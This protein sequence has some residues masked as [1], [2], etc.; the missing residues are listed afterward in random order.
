M[1]MFAKGQ[2][3]VI[4]MHKTG[5]VIFGDE[6]LYVIMEGLIREIGLKHKLSIIAC[7]TQRT[8][9]LFV[10]NVEC[11][12][13]LNCFLE[14]SLPLGISLTL[15]ELDSYF[16]TKIIRKQTDFVKISQKFPLLIDRNRKKNVDIYA[17]EFHFVH[18]KKTFY[19]IEV[20]LEPSAV[21]L[22]KLSRVI[23]KPTFC[24]CEIKDAVQLRGNRE[25]D[26]RLCFR[27]IDSTIPLLSKPEISRL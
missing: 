10:L 3:N 18:R 25:A 9:Q 26:Q 5:I 19:P 13:R 21:S 17:D 16:E 22:L 15:K 24:I 11:Y 27:Y 14:L 2:V 8:D 12:N 7:K 4:D 23:R 1:F 6:L 20:H